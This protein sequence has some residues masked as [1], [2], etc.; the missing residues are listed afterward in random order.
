MFDMINLPHKKFINVYTK[1]INMHWGEK[2]LREI[3]TQEMKIDP[4][5]GD[6]FLFFNKAMDKLKLFFIDYSGPQ[7]TM[8]VLS[9][10][11]FM[12]PISNKNEIIIRV[13]RKKLNAI[14]KC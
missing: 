12:L 1:P 8:K 3:C 2:K 14:F 6:I 11:G 5:N 13:E 10:G 4:T 7:E 9:R